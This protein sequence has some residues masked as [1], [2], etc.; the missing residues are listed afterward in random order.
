MDFFN[1]MDQEARSSAK[2]HKAPARTST[3]LPE[4]DRDHDR[5]LQ[6][7]VVTKRVQKEKL[8]VDQLHVLDYTSHTKEP[9]CVKPNLKSC[10]NLEN[11]RLL[12][13]ALPYWPG[14][15]SPSLQCLSNWEETTVPGHPALQ[16]QPGCG[17]PANSDST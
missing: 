15:G 5:N 11:K 12:C 3:D 10:A 7:K 8:S 2:S 13:P 4:L 1:E 16:S 9:G 17:S 6:S 14:C